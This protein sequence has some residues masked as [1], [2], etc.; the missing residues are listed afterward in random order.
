MLGIRI[1]KRNGRSGFLRQTC[2]TS[3]VSAVRHILQ[4]PAADRLAAPLQPTVAKSSISTH[5][6]SSTWQMG[7]KHIPLFSN[8]PWRPQLRDQTYAFLHM[9]Q[10]R[11]LRQLDGIFCKHSASIMQSWQSVCCSREPASGRE[12]MLGIRI[13]KRNGR[14]GF[15]GQTCRTNLCSATHRIF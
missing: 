13:P 11:N 6:K 2:R 7:K 4:T 1:P 8:K 3:L 14:S 9:T 10:I 5:C 15:L 12:W